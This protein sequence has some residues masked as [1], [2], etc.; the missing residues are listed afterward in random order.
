MKLLKAEWE[1]NQQKEREEVKCNMTWQRMTV[2]LHSNKQQ[3][4][5]KDGDQSMWVE[6][7]WPICRS[8]LKPIFVTSALCSTPSLRPATPCSTPAQAFPRMSTHHSAPVHRIFCMLH[9]IFRSTHMLWWIAEY[10][11]WKKVKTSLFQ[12]SIGGVFITFT[13]INCTNLRWKRAQKRH[14]YIYFC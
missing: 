6:H 5:E 13:M 8:A 3:R 7:D 10:Y 1:V 11:R 14:V 12:W 9:S 2:T 4:T